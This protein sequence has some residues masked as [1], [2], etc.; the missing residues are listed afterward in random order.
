MT[1]R[2]PSVTGELR[3]ADSALGAIEAAAAREKAALTHPKVETY[4]LGMIRLV[5]PAVSIGS[6]VPRR[7]RLPLCPF[8]TLGL[9]ELWRVARRV[10]ASSAAN[11]TPKPSATLEGQLEEAKQLWAGVRPRVERLEAPAAREALR[12]TDAPLGSN[13]SASIPAS[14]SVCLQSALAE[15]KNVLHLYGRLY[16][17]PCANLWSNRVASMLPTLAPPSR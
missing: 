3:R 5:G 16:H 6:R 17:A 13:G 7:S 2:L 12:Q 11:S 14:C 15:E 8:I 10:T 1:L 4:L 9:C